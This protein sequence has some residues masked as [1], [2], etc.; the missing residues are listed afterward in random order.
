[1]GWNGVEWGGVESSGVEW[2]GVE[3]SGEGW[4]GVAWSEEDEGGRQKHAFLLGSAEFHEKI[5][6]LIRKC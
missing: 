5:M 6:I 4:G 2:S 3:W 1:M